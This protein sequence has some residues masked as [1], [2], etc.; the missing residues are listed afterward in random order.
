MSSRWFF[1]NARL[2]A[3]SSGPAGQQLATEVTFRREVDGRVDPV[4]AAGPGLTLVGPGDV[5]GFD[6]SMVLREEP[7][8]G[9][10]PAAPNILASVEFAHADLP[11]LLSPGSVNTPAGGT[12]L[13]WI[14]L[15]VLEEEEAAAPRAA[16]PLPVLTAPV[17]VLPPLPERWAWAHVEA[18]LGDS[19][20]DRETARRQAEAGVRSQSAEV[21]ARLLCPRKLQANRGWIAAVVPVTNAGVAA[22]LGRNVVGV[23]GADAWPGGSDTIDLPVYHWWRFRTTENGA[24]EE[25][26]RRLRHRDATSAGLGSRIVDVSDPWHADKTGDAATLQL[27]TAQLDGAL[28]PPEVNADREI[29]LNPQAQETFVAEMI[30]R[31]D[32]PARNRELPDGDLAAD[33]D[34]TAV[35]PPLYGS[36]FAGVQTVPPDQG[37]WLNT[38]NVEVRRRVAAALGTRYV[39]LEQEFLMA[40]AW[41][42]VGAIR[43]ANRLLAATELAAAAAEQAQRKH[44]DPLAT[45][46]LLRAMSPL[47]NRIALTTEGDSGLSTVTLAAKMADVTVLPAATSTAFARLTRRGGALARRVARVSDTNVVRV[48]EPGST[49]A[50]Q[51]D[52]LTEARG[53]NGDTFAAEVRAAVD[54]TRLQLLRI[55]DRIPTESMLLRSTAA[56]RPLGPILKHPSFDVPMAEE[57]LTR[58][59]EWAI[60]GIGALPPNSVTPLETNPEFVA[61][62]LVGLNHEF[63][64]ELLWREFPTDQRGTAF[65]RFWPTEGADV[66]EIARWPVDSPL[67]GL[68]RDNQGDIAMLVRGE[69]LHRFPG[70]ALLAM[71]GVGGELPA[72]F[73]GQPGIPLALDES[74]VLYLFPGLT[75]DRA[76]AE[77]WFFVFREPMRG[78]QFGFDSGA[79]PATMDTWADLTWDGVPT[80]AAGFVQPGVAPAISPQ[81]AAPPDDPPVWGRD[82]ADQARIAFQ[83]PFQLAFGAAAMLGR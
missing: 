69:L 19:V 5:L 64:R 9:S 14:A 53:G 49:I 68:L 37:S 74:S 35:G 34:T 75:T 46:S 81:K 31:L 27:A 50:K 56:A 11:W 66:D 72:E 41:E 29:W 61:A 80:T 71:K 78:T 51:L 3:G 70:T 22:G 54:P 40:R 82:A 60:P 2:G 20:T 73:G 77:D 16:N 44:L 47:S 63:N 30:E 6:G 57:L 23:P 58:W 36:H 32:A 43:E 13:P 45:I 55:A 83:Q 10:A 76:T 26:A 8:P 42:Q 21:I 39:Q 15:I 28:R 59:P 12:P 25:L 38:L 79:Q 4:A 62:L 48:D 1:S 67:G 24:F 52:T 18:R 17:A 65:A 33:R 7:R